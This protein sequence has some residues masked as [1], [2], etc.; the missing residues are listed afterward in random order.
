VATF[1]R[2]VG[3]LELDRLAVRILFAIEQPVGDELETVPSNSTPDL[4]HISQ[5]LGAPRRLD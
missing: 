2:R 3:L 4:T 5:L 1:R